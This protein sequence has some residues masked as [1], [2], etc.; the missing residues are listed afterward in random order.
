MRSKKAKSIKTSEE[1]AHE[2][3]HSRSRTPVTNILYSVTRQRRKKLR[4]PTLFSYIFF[5]IAFRKLMCIAC[6]FCFNY[7]VIFPWTRKTH[8]ARIQS[9]AH[10]HTH[11][12]HLYTD[13]QTFKIHLVS[14]SFFFL[15]VCRCW[16]WMWMLSLLDVVYRA[17]CHLF[18]IILNNFHFIHRVHYHENDNKINKLN[19]PKWTCNIVVFYVWFICSKLPVYVHFIDNGWSCVSQIVY[20][21][22]IVRASEAS[23]HSL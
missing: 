9:N 20:F 15:S 19:M 4:L 14:E 10:T 8:R 3:A 7:C 16:W 13:T 6:I 22:H 23:I 21:S 1:E 5:A 18:C 17:E 12:S 2:K 11:T